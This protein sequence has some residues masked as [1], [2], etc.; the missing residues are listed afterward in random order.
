MTPWLILTATLPSHPSALRVRVWRALKATGAGPLRE[1]VHLLPAFAP[2]APALWEVEGLIRA[3]GAEAHLLEV[4]ARDAAQEQAFQALFDRADLY[5][6]LRQS[7]AE[8]HQALPTTS[9]AEL[10]KA[11]R[12]LTQQLH[13]IQATDF[14]PGAAGEQAA[15]ALRDLQGKVLRHLSPGEPQASSAAIERLPLGDFQGQTWATRHRPWVDRLASAWLIQRFIDA[16]PTFVWLDDPAQCPPTALGYDFDHARFSHVGNR[17]TFEVLTHSF[18]LDTDP[19][20]QRL[21]ALVHCIDVGGAPVDEAPGVETL[22][23]GLH[24]QHTSDDALLAACCPL[25]DALYAALKAHP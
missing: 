20:L 9:E 15:D 18:G 5:A 14:F 2:T 19:G 1:G 25:F 22:V 17:V 8:A 12:S 11:L 16:S 24:A 23:R 10:K 21:G 13:A 3:S 4:Q 6:E 7:V